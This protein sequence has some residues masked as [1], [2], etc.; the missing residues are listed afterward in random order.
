MFLKRKDDTVPKTIKIDLPS[1]QHTG[2]RTIL[3][4]RQLR[5][6]RPQEVSALFSAIEWPI[7]HL[8]EVAGSQ[9]MYTSA[10]PGGRKRV[11][12]GNDPL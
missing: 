12:T 6:S 10:L 11:T 4:C 8:T 7:C 1:T 2:I 5:K 9:S 3:S